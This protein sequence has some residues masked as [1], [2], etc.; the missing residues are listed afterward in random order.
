MTALNLEPSTDMSTNKFLMAMERFVSCCLGL[1]NTI[2][3]DNAT[4]IQASAEEW[5]VPSRIQRHPSTS[6]IEELLGNSSHHRQ[7]GQEDG[8]TEA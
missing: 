1:L 8:G 4:N 2:Y 3:S 6:Y 5:L 7:L